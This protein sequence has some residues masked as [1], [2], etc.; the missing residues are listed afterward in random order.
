MALEQLDSAC[1]LDSPW[2]GSG[3][4]DRPR[5]VVDW[6]T[7]AQ[8]SRA[9]CDLD[10]ERFAILAKSQIFTSKSSVVHNPVVAAG[11]ELAETVIFARYLEKNEHLENCGS[12]QPEDV[13]AQQEVGAVDPEQYREQ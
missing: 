6:S 10:R 5:T 2:F 1:E 12:E 3:N 9:T 8:K 7:S 4:R 11:S 13:F